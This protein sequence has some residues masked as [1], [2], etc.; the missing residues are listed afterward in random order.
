MENFSNFFS[1]SYADNL[2]VLGESISFKRIWKDT[3]TFDIITSGPRAE[4]YESIKGP[5]MIEGNSM[6]EVMFLT[7]YIGN[8]NIT[9]ISNAFIFENNGWAVALKRK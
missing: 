9:K 5:I 7:K 8:Y 2:T 1:N 4:V 3:V 6:A